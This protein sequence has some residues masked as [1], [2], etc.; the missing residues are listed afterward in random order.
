[1]KRAAK[2]ENTHAPKQ[3]LT[4]VS[5]EALKKVTSAQTCQQQLITQVSATAK[6]NEMSAHINQGKN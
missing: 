2:T 3:H 6:V 5:S 1:L 4:Q